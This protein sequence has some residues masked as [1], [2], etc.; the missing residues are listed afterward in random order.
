MEK[1]TTGDGKGDA[2]SGLG[3]VPGHKLHW[4]GAKDIYAAVRMV[5]LMVKRCKA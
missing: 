2:D 3:G 5:S 4:S 1:G